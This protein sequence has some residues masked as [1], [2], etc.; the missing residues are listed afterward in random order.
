[1]LFSLVDDGEQFLA[2]NKN[3]TRGKALKVTTAPGQLRHLEC[4]RACC[5]SLYN[6]QRP[7]GVLICGINVPLKIQVQMARIEASN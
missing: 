3:E 1:M 4:A 7:V 5:S 2:Q 6:P